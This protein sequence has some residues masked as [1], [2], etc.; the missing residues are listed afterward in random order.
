M[1]AQNPDAP[2]QTLSLA[3]WPA[4]L[5]FPAEARSHMDAQNPDAPALKLEAPSPQEGGP[6]P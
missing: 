3:A 6:S 5:F 4:L 1:D 2:A